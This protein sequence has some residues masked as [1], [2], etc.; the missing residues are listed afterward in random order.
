MAKKCL[1]ATNHPANTL[2]SNK[3]LKNT[4]SF[5]LKE[6]VGKAKMWNSCSGQ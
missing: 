1:L 5:D 6:S 4:Y 3:L 2:L